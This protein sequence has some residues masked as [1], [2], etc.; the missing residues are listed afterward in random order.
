MPS[1]SQR[2][3]RR[4]RSARME[5]RQ[6]AEDDTSQ[7][8]WMG[9]AG[10]KFQPLS[11]DDIDQI[12]ESV[13]DL[14][15]TLGLSQA[16]Q[17]VIDVVV[18]NGGTFT[19]EARLLFPRKLVRDALA[20]IRRDVTLWSRRNGYHLDVSGARVHVGSGG[21]APRI[22]DM[23]TDTYRETTIRDLYDMARI[24]DLQEHIHFFSRPVVGT[25]AP[26]PF[27]LDINT[28]YAC[29]AGTSKHICISAT[30]PDHVKSIAEICY[31]VAGGEDNFRERPFLTIMA[32]HVVPPMRFAT[33]SCEIVEEAV[34]YGLPVQLI[35]AGQMGATSPVTLAGSIVQAV[36]ESLAG[37]IFAWLIDPGAAI[38]FAPKP[39]V[40]DLRTGAMCGGGGEQA[41]V[42]AS[43]AQ[44]GR[45]YGLPV[46]CI[47][48][49]SDSKVHDAQAGYEK[50]L[51]VT[52]AAHA[53]CNMISHACGTLASML[54][55]SLESFIIDNDMLGGV[56]R[57]IHGVEVTPETV[58]VNAIRDV[59]NGEGHYLGHPQTLERMETDYVYPQVADRQAPDGWAEDGSLD[60][61]ERARVKARE[62]LRDHHPVYLGPSIDA[63]LRSQY[64]IML[65]QLIV[66]PD[67]NG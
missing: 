29:L 52:L 67:A 4:G 32:T 62:I 65:P 26:N 6:Q 46:A 33:E 47:A 30:L 50:N 54:G 7:S 63:E 44:M 8:K 12:H 64:N 59:V 22:L 23:D 36:A 49:Y 28:L 53:G 56:L 11:P 34:R 39:L 3:T 24:V 10:G 48:G 9:V 18:A 20:G 38:I 40:S 41:V 1:G 21:A 16:S 15:E 19:D 60:M 37:V 35:S 13:L 51:S 43:A 25:D 55:S 5:Q 66:G 14:L 61:L 45:Y 2:S 58:A 42:M 17:G 57:S 31:A 27:D